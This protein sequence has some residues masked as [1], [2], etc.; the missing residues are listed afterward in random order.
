MGKSGK[1]YLIIMAVL[2]AL[3]VITNSDWFQGDAE[4]PGSTADPVTV[5]TA[6]T[7][8]LAPTKKPVVVTKKPTVPAV[9]PATPTPVPATPTP[10]PATPTPVPKV[11]LFAGYDI[12]QYRT[13][14]TKLTPVAQR[15]Y[16]ELRECIV[17]DTKSCIIWDVDYK[18]YANQVGIAQEALLYDFPEFFWIS[19]GWS[20][21]SVSENGR[22]GIRITPTLR[23]YWTKLSNR[24]QHIA[25]V[26]DRAKE[27]ANAAMSRYSSAYDQLKYINDWI[28]RNTT[29]NTAA[30]ETNKSENR[31]EEHL[32]AF[33]AYGVFVRK[34]AVCQGYALAFKLI[35]NMCGYPCEYVSGEGNGGDHGWNYVTVNGKSY[36]MD[37]TWNDRDGGMS[38]AVCRYTYFLVSSKYFCRD[39]IVDDTNFTA[40]VCNDNSMDFFSRNLAHFTQYDFAAINAS[41][42]KQIAVDDLVHLR[43]ENRELMDMAVQYLFGE[44]KQW[45]QLDIGAYKNVTYYRD[46]D[47]LV[48]SIKF[49][50]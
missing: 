45:R 25:A 44:P 26:M 22:G 34:S 39:H 32:Y 50:A 3:V 6:A 2:I 42:K 11:N 35:A 37:V 18:T 41:V 31:P 20:S 38:G 5:T 28:C 46:Y 19:R 48:I 15:I 27:V 9:K 40:P 14:Y 1:A 17:Y 4:D 10:K 49:K 23:S 7:P 12:P 24:E 36:W 29:Y 16:R 21:K 30:A 13:M 33:S 8:T 47:Q 43:F